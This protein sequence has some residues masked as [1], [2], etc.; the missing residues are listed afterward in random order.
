MNLVELR[1]GIAILPAGR[2]K[3]AISAAI[4]QHIKKRFGNRIL[5]FDNAA[6]KD[7]PSIC[8]ATQAKGTPLEGCGRY[9]SVYCFSSWLTCSNARYRAI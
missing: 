1:Y 4:E 2:R 7:Y 6:S 5:E 9:H 8:A 3:N